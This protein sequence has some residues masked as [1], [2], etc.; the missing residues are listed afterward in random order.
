MQTAFLLPTSEGKDLAYIDSSPIAEIPRP[1]E[2]NREEEGEGEA[3][4]GGRRRLSLRFL[5]ARPPCPPLFLFFFPLASLEHDVSFLPPRVHESFFLGIGDETVSLE[6]LR[7]VRGRPLQSNDPIE[8]SDRRVSPLFALWCKER[9]D[10][11]T[12]GVR[13]AL[14]LPPGEITFFLLR[15]LSPR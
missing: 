2:N 3:R 15:L 10:G 4:K 6:W 14:F 13:L 7:N 12:G 11:T 8:L 5:S 9:L 1:V